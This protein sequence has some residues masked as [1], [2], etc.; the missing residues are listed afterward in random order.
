MDTMRI[1]I[2]C[3]C[4]LPTAADLY[5]QSVRGTARLACSDSLAELR[6]RKVPL[7]ENANTVFAFGYRQVAG[8]NQDPVL[9]R[10]DSGK[11]TYCRTDYETTQAE[12]RIYGLL[13]A[14]EDLYAVAS[15]VGPPGKADQDFRRFARKGWMRDSGKGSPR[16]AIILKI[17]AQSGDVESAA[18]LT[19]VKEDGNS[20]SVEVLEMDLNSKGLTVKANAWLS[21]RMTSRAPM[22]CK[23]KEPYLQT[24]IFT[25]D[26]SKTVDSFAERCVCCE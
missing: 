3:L 2:F 13:L 21:P 11:R 26:L 24:I 20:N 16:A 25:P 17:K 1:L 22:Q 5:S 7:L 6:K 23:G 12:G 15:L 8:P 10:F 4:V 19:S 14:G 18:Y 9:I